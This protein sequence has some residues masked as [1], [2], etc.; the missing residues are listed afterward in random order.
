MKEKSKLSITNDQLASAIATGVLASQFCIA[1][2][3]NRL[4]EEVTLGDEAM[5]QCWVDA[6]RFIAIGVKELGFNPLDE[7]TKR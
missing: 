7:V 3:E 2:R 1:E 6:A 5:R 4:H